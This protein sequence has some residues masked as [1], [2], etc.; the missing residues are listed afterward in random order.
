MSSNLAVP[1]VPAAPAAPSVQAGYVAQWM[2]LVVDQIGH[3]IVLLSPQ[4]RLLYANAA[5]RE[6]IGN[7]QVL[8]VEDGI[9]HGLC[10][11]D[12]GRLALGLR[13]AQRGRRGMV[14][15][16]CKGQE[17]TLSLSPI[18]EGAGL[19][20]PSPRLAEGRVV[21]IVVI[22]GRR[23]TCEADGLL[24][25]GRQNGLTPAEIRVL[26]GLAS[27]R[28]PADIARDEGRA[29]ST[30]RTHIRNVLAKTETASVRLLVSR[31]SRLPPMRAGGA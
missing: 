3:G 4:G 26:A 6:Q 23:V 11:A 24:A 17:R 25:F 29:E 19:S 21:A 7:A 13:S 30:V 27:E 5:A 31:L 16:S 10:A 8:R 2:S 20:L 9:V 12:E 1:V 18:T 15:L 28:A 14:F 22:F